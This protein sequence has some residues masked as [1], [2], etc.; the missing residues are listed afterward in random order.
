MEFVCA[1][2]QVATK[3]TKKDLDLQKVDNISQPPQQ[4]S[5]TGSLELELRSEWGY[6]SFPGAQHLTNMSHK[7]SSLLELSILIYQAEF[8]TLNTGASF[9]TVGLGTWK[10]WPG[11]VGPAVTHALKS[12]L[13]SLRYMYVYLAATSMLIAPGSIAM[14]LKLVNR[15]NVLLEKTFF[16]GKTFG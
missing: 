3:T 5:M 13:V 10:S 8:V 1:Q 12:G 14:N 9:P 16:V 2:I 11:M 7:S 6:S 4:H 15:L